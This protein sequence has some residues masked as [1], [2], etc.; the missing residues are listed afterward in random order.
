MMKRLP[1]VIAVAALASGGFASAALAGPSQNTQSDQNGQASSGNWQQNG[2]WA[3]NRAAFL[4]ARLAAL[5]AGLELNPDQEKLWPPVE[6]AIRD[7]CKLVTSQWRA[8][9]NEEQ[10]LN[11]VD[12][13]EKRSEAI[14]ARGQALKKIA[15]AAKPLYA[16]LNDAQKERLPILLR[17]IRHPFMSEFHHHHKRHHREWRNE[18][19][20][21][22]NWRNNERHDENWR[23]DEDQRHQGMEEPMNGNQMMMEHQDQENHDGYRDRDQDHDDDGD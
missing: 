20:H 4:N 18:E 16:T 17:A 8:H 12:R 23:N 2:S 15:D 10:G 3:Q 22:E 9:R 1:I 19:R 21:D 14:T 13:L 11:P 7:F 6:S 5:H